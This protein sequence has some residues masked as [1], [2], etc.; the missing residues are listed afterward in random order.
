[1]TVR[2]MV[3][4]SLLGLVLASVRFLHPG[5]FPKSH[6]DEG[7]WA[8]GSRNLVRYGDS[9]LDGRLH[10]YL[11]PGTL[12]LV[13]GF[14]EMA[15]ANLA[16]ARLFSAILGLLTCGLLGLIAHRRFANRPWLVPLLFG[17]SSLTILIHRMIL[18]E[19]DQMFWLVLAAMFWLSN[20]RGG[21]IAAG[22]A[23]GVAL[24]VKSNSLYVIPAFLL[25]P[26]PGVRVVPSL[27]LFLTAALLIGGGGYVTA[28]SIHPDDFTRAFRYE[29]ESTHFLDEGVLF[30]IGRFGLNP[31]LAAQVL[32]EFLTADG[33]LVLL[34][35]AGLVKVL[36][37]WK[38][39]DRTQRLFA[40]WLLGGLCFH[41]GQIY[42]QYRYLTTLAPALAFLA[43]DVIAGLLDAAEGQSQKILRC[44]A[45]V[46][47]SVFCLF[48]L[49]RVGRGILRP[50]NGDY[51]QSVA[52]VNEHVP[53]DA[54]VLAAPVINLSLT[55]KGFDFFRSLVPYEGPLRT[56]DEVVR[57]RK[58]DWIIR[59]PEWREYE[60]PA[61]AQ[62]LAERCTLRQT[63][64]DIA[65]YQVRREP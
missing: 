11:S 27:G 37:H 39:A 50:T 53:K 54:H 29:L 19:A 44:A 26:R 41:F 49:G 6:P 62:Y 1:M 17:L 61:M 9:T 36:L 12:V 13:A 28:W 51:W 48:H 7:F 42:V 15:P 64:G 33:L 63:V 3:V 20:W 34:G 2:T 57:D 45:I 14:F 30:H 24:L 40:L 22:A 8:C 10:P 23:L 60:T 55:P 32:V 38:S 46:F 25:T 31:R 58:I 43:A 18:L 59:D 5:D 21:G 4:L 52:W 65:I 16:T 35:L 56:L 47:L